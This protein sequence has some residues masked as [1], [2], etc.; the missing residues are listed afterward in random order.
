MENWIQTMATM[1]C[2]LNN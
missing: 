1:N 2:F